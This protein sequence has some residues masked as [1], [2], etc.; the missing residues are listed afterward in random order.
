VA[1]QVVA[2]VVREVEA[3]GTVVGIHDRAQKAETNVK[4][5]R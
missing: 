2:D 3:I 1:V 4:E 5:S